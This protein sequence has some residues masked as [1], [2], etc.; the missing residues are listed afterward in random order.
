M[1]KHTFHQTSAYVCEKKT[2][3]LVIKLNAISLQ[4]FMKI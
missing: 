3:R 2:K 1:H 4:D